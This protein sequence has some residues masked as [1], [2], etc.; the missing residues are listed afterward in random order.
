MFWDI[1]VIVASVLQIIGVIVLI[2]NGPG[3]VRGLEGLIVPRADKGSP[4]A[5]ETAIA[6]SVRR[7]TRVGLALVVA[8]IILQQ[9]AHWAQ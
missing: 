7:R 9:W 6:A 8:G 5:E 2:S 1:L 3:P 4:T